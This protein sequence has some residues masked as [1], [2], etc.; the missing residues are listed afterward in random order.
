MIYV[1]SICKTEFETESEALECEKSHS[2]D[3]SAID[4]VFKTA[5]ELDTEHKQH[6][7]KCKKVLKEDKDIKTRY[8]Y[9]F[10]GRYCIPCSIEL[11]KEI[12]NI[13]S[14]YKTVLSG[15]SYLN[16]IIQ[17]IINLKN[18]PSELREYLKNL[19]VVLNRKNK[20]INNNLRKNIKI[21]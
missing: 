7:V 19:I 18:N 2:G 12:I 16:E 5:T 9:L 15:Y 13:I 6:C 17:T 8:R 21:E 3:S 20:K 1:C 14:E 11:E 10:G 4:L